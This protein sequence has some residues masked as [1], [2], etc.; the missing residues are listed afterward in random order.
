MVAYQKPHR[1]ACAFRPCKHRTP[2]ILQRCRALLD[3][4]DRVTGARCPLSRAPW[5]KIRR[6]VFG[7]SVVR[8]DVFEHP[9][10]ILLLGIVVV[11]DILGVKAS[12]QPIP[13]PSVKLGHRLAVSEPVP[14][15]A[16]AEARSFRTPLGAGGR[17]T[18]RILIAI[19]CLFDGQVLHTGG[20][21]ADWICWRSR[22]NCSLN[23]RRWWGLLTRGRC[24]SRIRTVT[25]GV[26]A[27]SLTD[28]RRA[29]E[30]RSI[31]GDRG[32]ICVFALSVIRT[33][34]YEILN[35]E[36]GE[37]WQAE[38]VC[39]SS[40]ITQAA[41]KGS[42]NLGAG[43]FSGDCSN[44]LVQVLQFVDQRQEQAPVLTNGLP[45]R[46]LESRNAIC[47]K[48]RVTIDRTSDGSR[49]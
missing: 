25:T 21:I 20:K 13:T 46:A 19:G 10:I 26:C 9:G 47:E 4:E 1:S 35:G 12:G 11:G 41:D 6:G 32:R 42:S 37:V 34:T 44:V 3:L 33:G 27:R 31:G 29:P 30:V 2:H 38:G 8:A 40:A 23:C 24:R 28:S 22:L 49:F 16:A 17:Q 7:V 15:L 48:R 39:E 43:E 36:L 45:F 5:E 18:G 14:S